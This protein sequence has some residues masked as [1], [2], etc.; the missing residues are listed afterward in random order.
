[1]AMICASIPR[2]KVAEADGLLAQVGSNFRI[3]GVIDQIDFD[4]EQNLTRVDDIL[5]AAEE[6]AAGRPEDCIELLA[7]MNVTWDGLARE[8][9]CDNVECQRTFWD[10]VLDFLLWLAEQIVQILD[11]IVDA[12]RVVVAWLTWIATALAALALA[13]A[14][15]VGLFTGGVGAVVV[16][17]AESPILAVLGIVAGLGLVASL[18]LFGLDKL[19]EWLQQIIRDA[20]AKFCGDGIPSLPDWDPSGPWFPPAFPQ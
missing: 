9:A 18:L 12:L 5:S 11:Y 15:V 3:Q 2:D 20:R 7:T 10:H 13:I 8:A 19:V 14:V 1:M 6:L 17:V 4:P 16:A